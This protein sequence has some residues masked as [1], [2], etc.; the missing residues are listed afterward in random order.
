MVE[1]QTRFTL[2]F[3]SHTNALDPYLE[4]FKKRGRLKSSRIVSMN[5]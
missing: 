5:G 4:A 1:G 3:E 2:V